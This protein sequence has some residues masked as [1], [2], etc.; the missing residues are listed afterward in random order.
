M[1]GDEGTGKTRCLRALAGDLPETPS[2]VPD[3][4]AVWLDLSLPGCDDHKPQ[5]VW[6]ALRA[7]CPA[8]NEALLQALALDLGLQP[9]LDKRLSML[10]TGTRRKV[11]L[12]GLLAAQATVTCLDQPYA[13]LDMA[14]IRVIR[15]YL[16]DQAAHPTRTWVVAD[17]EADAH[18][19]W[20]RIVRL[21]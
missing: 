4:D 3:R 19:P 21:G 10:S 15:G 11:A 14:S 18:L 5:D 9:H 7:R 20:Q 8:W 13:A 12:A 2:P 1:V 6:A 17:Y 16:H